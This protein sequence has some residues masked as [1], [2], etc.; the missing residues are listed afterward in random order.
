MWCGFLIRKCA[1]ELFTANSSWTTLMEQCSKNLIEAK[2]KFPETV[3]Q[4]GN[5]N[6]FF[7]KGKSRLL[8]PALLSPPP[9]QESS[10]VARYKAE[11]SELVYQP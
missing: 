1:F 4:Y 2:G 10:K 6:I 3:C 8:P 7:D 9:V 5:E 11:V